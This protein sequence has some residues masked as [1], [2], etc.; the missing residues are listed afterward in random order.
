MQRPWLGINA[1][2]AH[3]RIFI[4]KV[5]SRGP[6]EKAG[7]RPG[8]MVL[9]VDGKEVKG[10]S[11]FY[12]R[13]WGVGNAGVQVPLTVLQGVKVIELLV[14]SGDRQKMLKPKPRKDVAI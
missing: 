11:D 8:D 10:L 9:M 3:D 6:A 13:A 12:R 14:R 5:T 4:T 2:E 7:L 1:E